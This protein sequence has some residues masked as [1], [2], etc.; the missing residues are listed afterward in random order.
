MKIESIVENLIPD[1]MI[2]RNDIEKIVYQTASD[3]SMRSIDRL[4][5]KLIERSVVQRVS[6]SHFLV[7]NVGNAKPTY[8]YE[9]SDYA[10]NVIK[11]IEEKYPLVDLQIWELIQF[12]EFVNHQIGNNVVF[13]EVEKLLMDSVYNTLVEIH[14]S[15]LI[16]PNEELFYTYRSRDTIVVQNLISET[17][18]SVKGTKSCCLEK[19]LVDLFSQKLVG[20]LFQRAEYPTIFEEAFSKFL[21][22]EKKMLR[23]ARR[24]NLE[25]VVIDFIDN[26][27]NIMLLTERSNVG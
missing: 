15:V 18:T 13:V 25:K 24:R 8:S 14:T 19:M 4:I 2:T 6:K 22:D 9:H 10:Q 27:T 23:Y 12:N 1:S 5:S 20:H 16:A 21:I 3:Y 7:L 26:K 17:P 11:I